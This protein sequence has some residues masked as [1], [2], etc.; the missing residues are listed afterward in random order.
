MDVSIFPYKRFRKGQQ[1]AIKFITNV[2]NEDAIGFLHAPTGIGKTISALVAHLLSSRSDI[3]KLVVLTRTKSQAHI[4]VKEIEQIK[5]KLSEIGDKQLRYVVFR[6]KKDMCPIA[7]KK[8]RLRRM[9]YAIFLKACELL[10]SEKKCTFFNKSYTG[11]IPSGLLTMAAEEAIE[12][13][14]SWL[15]ILRIS[16]RYGVCPYEVARYI[17][18][19]A[20]IIIGSYSY[21]F[22]HDIREK[23]LST[24]GESLSTIRIIIDEA[25]NLPDFIISASSLGLSTITIEQGIQELEKLEIDEFIYLKDL[26]E[27]FLEEINSTADSVLG[28]RK[29]GPRIVDPRSF[30]RLISHRDIRNLREAGERYI[31][32]GLDFSSRLLWI[33]EFFDYLISLSPLDEFLV[34]IEAKM[35]ERAE[36]YYVLSI[37]LLDPSFEAKGLFRDISTAVL[38]SGSLYPLNYYETILGLKDDEKLSPR[39]RELILPSPFP[40]DAFSV[41]VDKLSTTKYTERNDEMFDLIASRLETI[42]SSAP[43]NKAI[44]VVF[45]SYELLNTIIFKADITSRE[46]IPET[47][48]TEIEHVLNRLEEE[49]DAMILAVAGGK[50]MEGIDY[51]LGGETLLSTVVLVGLPFPE[52]NDITRAQEEY[53]TKKFGKNLGRFLAIIVPAIRKSLQAAGRLIRDEKDRGI[54]IILD[55]RFKDHNYWSYFPPN[56]RR[57]RTFST[58]EELRQ[59]IKEFFKE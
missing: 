53:F 27:A 3:R 38:M 1:E 15:N 7:R 48:E 45:P 25:H 2:F 33:S 54:V 57:Y 28:K 58:N 46:I 56:W 49:R 36:R 47:R 31:L 21:I 9:P 26:L 30:T 40:Q 11:G 42:S 16:I 13:G 24:I 23:F 39:I 8:D 4:Y 51:R 55:R 50:L 5:T 6:S 59:L 10:K 34:T 52:W 41:I 32:S 19:Q 12:K 35:T 44:L 17:A 14:A 29:P 22:R 43:R 37:E 20:D 18:S